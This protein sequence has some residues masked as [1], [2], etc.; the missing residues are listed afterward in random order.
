MFALHV[1]GDQLDRRAGFQPLLFP[2]APIRLRPRAGF[3]FGAHRSRRLRRTWGLVL[4]ETDTYKAQEEESHA[5]NPH[6]PEV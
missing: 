4:R 2:L 1:V 5:D 3:R 6:G